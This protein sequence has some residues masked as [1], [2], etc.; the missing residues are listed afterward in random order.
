MFFNIVVCTD[1]N[2]GIGK[3]NNIP[4]KYSKD[5]EYFKNLT[6]GNN[7]DLRF[8]K[9]NVVIMGNNTYNS[10]PSSF[11][12]LK[13]RIN[14][15]LSKSV[16]ST[17][18]LLLEDIEYIKNNPIYFSNINYLLLY[19]D[20]IKK[21][22][23][24]CFVIGGSQIYDLF[25]DLKLIRHIYLTK[26]NDI[27]SPSSI[28]TLNNKQ[29]TY[30]CDKFF[31]FENYKKQFQL[32]NT[33]YIIDTDKISHKTN[34]LT[35]NTYSYINKE[36][37]KF[38]KT[39]NKILDKGVY[40]IDRSTVGTLSIFGKSFTYDIRNYRL[41]LFTHRKIFL[42]GIIEELIFF[43][44]GKSDTKV[45]EEKKV[46]IWKGHTSRDFLNSRG[47]EYL[48][49]G[50]M[51]AGYGHQLRHFSAEYENAETDYTGKGF[52][53]LQYIIDQI[54]HN[55]TSRRIVFSYWNPSAFDKTALHPC[56]PKDTL[57]LTNNGY[58]PIQNVDIKDKLYTHKGNWESII[59]KQQKEYDDDIYTIKCNYNTKPIETTK[60]HP[61]YVKEYIKKPD[62]TIR[63][64]TKLP[65]WC[66]A[67]DLNKN[68]H[69]I[70]FPI[71]KKQL[72]PE[73]NILKELNKFKQINI[74][75]KLDNIDEYYMMGYYI[76][77]G[78][79]ELT[80]GRNVFNICFK[81][82]KPEVYEIISKLIHLTLKLETEKIKTYTC[83]NKI[84]WT[85]LK[86]F[87][88]LAH[89]KKIPEWIQDSPKEFIQAFIDG[90]TAAD[91]TIDYKYTTV[92][93]DL[94]YGLQRLYAKLGKIIS[95][96]F[97]KKNPTTII[98][99][100]IVNQRDLYHMTLI[101]N[102]KKKY[103]KIVDDD[104]IYFPIKEINI[105]KQNIM[106]YNFEVNNDN[107]YTVQNLSVHNCH[108][109]YQFY[110]NTETS[111]LSCSF[112]QRSND[113]I[114][115]N[116]FNICSASILVFMLCKICNLK[117]GR[118]VHTI[119]DIH[120]YSSQLDVAKEIVENEPFNFPLLFIE[121]P[122]YEIKKI[123]DFKSEHFKLLFY[124]SHKKYNIPMA[125]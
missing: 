107:S 17:N 108:I 44:S 8:E 21:N 34:T 93:K 106:V 109:L 18:M 120:I 7:T 52:D 40:N 1:N 51:G 75:K 15:I 28:H 100:R 102:C 95:V 125:I 98:Q 14:M 60:E 23:N 36:E 56:F 4:W 25:L 59:N 6:I 48:K 27:S 62:G 80:K 39:V 57:I 45:L 29:S 11:K 13:D 79:I 118:V 32:K 124:N 5:I 53:Q 86:E 37:N 63:D 42:R 94:A 9:L 46:N 111:E 97:Q 83:S 110:V 20:K 35:V 77:D 22:I 88:H 69:V 71:N 105:S 61:F 10:I 50:D 54:K 58:K 85:I 55:P 33:D 89:N 19:I 3:N 82:H 112:Y 113:Y 96:K 49:E 38:I 123:E 16:D 90:Y 116:C 67:K 31:N 117:P 41:P 78:W 121:D 12:P 99:N 114:L 70:C 2:Y 104:Y 87:G 64:Y 26:I 65:Y 74:N 103:V 115:A 47:L 92:S 24:E 122:K 73:F 76:G 72:I 101:T 43:I 84:W 81:K 68:K 91:G 66:P 30:N 119:G